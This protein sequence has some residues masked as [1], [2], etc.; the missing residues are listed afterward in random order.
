MDRNTQKYLTTNQFAKIFNINKKTLIYYDEIDLFKPAFVKENGYRCYTL[1]QGGLFEVILI[2]KKLG[3]PLKSIKEYLEK[4]SPDELAKILSEQK[5]YIENQIN[6]LNKINNSIKNKLN[7]L[8]ISKNIIF[9]KM[10]IENMEEE[11]MFLSTTVRDKDEITVAKTLFEHSNTLY[12]GFSF[13][14]IITDNDIINGDYLNYSYFYT[15]IEKRPKGINYFIKPKGKYLVFYYNGSCLNFNK[16]YDL[17]KKYLKDNSL[18]ITGYTYEEYIIDD[19]ASKT[20][21]EYITKFMI[22]IS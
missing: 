13:G 1:H 8:N 12:N 9:D 5:I 18:T 17:A 15:K 7:I 3:M 21:D 2:L 6:D 16:L 22:Q 14:A 19:A 20:P 11:Y 4:R 10:V